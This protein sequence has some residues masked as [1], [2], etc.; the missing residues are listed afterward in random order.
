[1]AQAEAFV[2]EHSASMGSEAATAAAKEQFLVPLAAAGERWI[3]N[4]P[5]LVVCNSRPY[6]DLTNLY[7]YLTRAHDNI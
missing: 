3:L 1:M 5:I 6:E 2:A 4:W 7:Y